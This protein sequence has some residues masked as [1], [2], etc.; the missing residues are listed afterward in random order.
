M[1]FPFL[2]RQL[3]KFEEQ[4]NL[5]FNVF[6]LRKKNQGNAWFAGETVNFSIDEKS[7]DGIAFNNS[8]DNTK[9]FQFV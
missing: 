5:S 2:L 1:E 4:N 6:P 7:Y 9:T 3:N 8:E